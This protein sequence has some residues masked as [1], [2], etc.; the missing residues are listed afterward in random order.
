MENGIEIL[1]EK[2][3][4]L[5]SAVSLEDHDRVPVIGQADFWPVTYSKRYSMQEAYYSIDVLA[6]C[7]KE[8]FS[9]FNGWDAFDTVMQSL[10]PMLDATGSMRFKVPGR[11]LSPNA[12]FQHPDLT[13]MEAEEYGEL[14]N[15]PMKFQIETIIP[16][17]CKRIG[18]GDFSTLLKALG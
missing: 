17:L 11:D 9:Q 3:A 5:R 15:D 16:R 4:R 6:E 12:E 10:G 8:A 13:L 2:I 14:I 1:D 7:Y 18:S